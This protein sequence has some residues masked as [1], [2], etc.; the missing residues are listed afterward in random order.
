MDGNW[1]PLKVDGDY[2]N[3]TRIT[4]LI[5]WDTLG[6]NKKGTDDGWRVGKKTMKKLDKI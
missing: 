6:W 5:Y 4:V 3:K 1:F 2:G